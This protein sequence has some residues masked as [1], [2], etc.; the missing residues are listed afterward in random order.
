MD[1]LSAERK[2]LEV[3]LAGCGDGKVTSVLP[4][5]SLWDD[6][7]KGWC[8]NLGVR[9]SGWEG[10]AIGQG[11]VQRV[12]SVLYRKSCCVPTLG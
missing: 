7:G 9:G 11:G 12:T 2:S 5:L 6:V 4:F 1:H 10:G 3:L 8:S